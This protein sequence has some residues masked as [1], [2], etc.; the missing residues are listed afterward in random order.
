ME[1]KISRGSDGRILTKVMHI[2][3]SIAKLKIL[4]PWCVENATDLVYC[5]ENN[6]TQPKCLNCSRGLN[7]PRKLYCNASCQG[8]YKGF[9]PVKNRVTWNKGIKLD[10]SKHISKTNPDKWELVKA[11]ISKA[12]SGSNN[13]MFG[14]D[15]QK[16]REKQS[17]TMRNKILHGEF[18]P[19]TNNRWTK[20]DI[21]YN[22]KKYRSSWEA[23]YASI[24]PQALHEN[25]R[26]KYIDHDGKE[27]IYISDFYNSISNE[28]VEIRP[29]SLYDET[30]PKVIAIKEYCKNNNYTY[31][32][33][34]IDYFVKN[35]HLI[36]Y[37]GLG[38]SKRK[39]INA[40]NKYERD[41]K[42]RG[43]L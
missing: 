9:P 15:N 23:S 41:S 13:G 38:E 6:I 16:Q 42:A 35:Q 39:I 28:I 19:N 4:Y 20:F 37:D 14:W 43:C 22:G 11:K 40:I 2:D 33:I 25:I 26:I 34:D 7:K 10:T 12:N 8:K 1:I 30:H 29:E 3:G 17:Q 36:D 31:T 21:E 24:N 27:R 18:T 5:Y 32:H